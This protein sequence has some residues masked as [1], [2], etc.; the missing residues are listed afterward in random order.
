MMT[1]DCIA[2]A[3][4]ARLYARQEF[5]DWRAAVMAFRSGICGERLRGNLDFEGRPSGFYVLDGI[6]ERTVAEVRI[7]VARDV[8]LTVVGG[9]EAL[10]GV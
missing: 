3:I 1:A 5:V 10:S 7:A 2:K 9:G 6:L 8:T 4:R